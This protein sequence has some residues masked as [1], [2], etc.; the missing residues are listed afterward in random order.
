MPVHNKH[1]EILVL[2]VI[3][4]FEWKSNITTDTTLF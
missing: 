3:H 2:L 4:E 1:L